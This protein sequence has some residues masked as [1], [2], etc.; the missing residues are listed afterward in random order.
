MQADDVGR[1]RAGLVGAQHV[2]VRQ[3]LDGVGLLDQGALAGHAHGAQGVGQDDGQDQAVGDQADDHGRRLD[4]GDERQVLGDRLEDDQPH[5]GERDD[6]Q[7]PHEHVGLVLQ[8][9]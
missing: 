9:R 4:A 2:D 6:E 5:E 8:R 7:D 3:R 1:Q